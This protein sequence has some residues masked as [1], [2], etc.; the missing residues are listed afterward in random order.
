MGSGYDNTASRPAYEEAKDDIE[1]KRS[2]VL[3]AI[4]SLGICTDK[5]IGAYLKW[6]INKVTPRRNELCADGKVRSFKYDKDPSTGRKVNWWVV[7]NPPQ[8]IDNA[9]QKNLFQ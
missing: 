7:I 8:I 5:M 6:E 2:K 4:K 9:T 3:N 1:T